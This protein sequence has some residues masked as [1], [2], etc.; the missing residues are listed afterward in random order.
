MKGKAKALY[1]GHKAQ[2][3]A[4]LWEGEQWRCSLSLAG[5]LR[6][7]GRGD[8]LG[9]DEAQDRGKRK[10]QQGEGGIHVLL[11]LRRSNAA[12]P[13]TSLRHNEVPFV[14]KYQSQNEKPQR[15]N[16]EATQFNR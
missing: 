9:I 4:E 15:A 2:E 10:P 14:V 8:E 6:L 7:A 12:T 1:R 13:S 16:E 5:S 11:G 3:R